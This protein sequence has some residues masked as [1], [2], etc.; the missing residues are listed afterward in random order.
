MNTTMSSKSRLTVVV[1]VALASGISLLALGTTC[2]ADTKDWSD[3][4]LYRPSVEQFVLELRPFGMHFPNINAFD[5]YFSG[6][7]GPLLSFELDYMPVRIPYVGMIG[8]GI[9]AGWVNWEGSARTAG[10]AQTSEKTSLEMV[11]LALLLA[12]RV[13]VLAREAKV[14]IV[15]TGKV[16][17]DLFYWGSSP[18]P[19]DASGAVSSGEDGW[20]LGVRFAGKASLELDFLAPRDARRLDD[21]W[22]INHTELFFEGYYSLAGQFSRRQLDVGGFGF[23]TGLGFTF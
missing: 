12:L 15:L 22:G 19:R 3:I 14:P 7:V 18:G 9:S 6:D 16:G 17:P 4:E 1:G 5:T 23:T 20:S 10:G 21:E 8:A 13:D 11:P 2:R